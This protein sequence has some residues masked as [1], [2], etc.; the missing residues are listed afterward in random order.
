MKRSS[1][2]VVCLSVFVLGWVAVANA[3]ERQ[4]LFGDLHVHTRLSLDAW[5]FG[6]RTSPDDAYRFAKGEAIPHPSGYDIQLDRPLDFYAVTDHAN[7]LGVLHAMAD[8]ADPASKIPGA[9]RF[10]QEKATVR[11]RRADYAHQSQFA[12]KH[13]N[14][15]MKRSA[16]AR[17][18]E[19]ANRHNDPGEFTAF[20]GYE[21]TSHPRGQPA[22]E[23]HLPRQCRAGC[24]FQPFRI[25]QSGRAVGVDGRAPWPR[26]RGAG[27]PA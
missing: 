5:G 25:A 13:M 7:Y 24:A 12:L 21:Y 10:T 8:P 4:A 26:H 16:W 15:D 3:E 27:D 23:C 6:T 20:I 19:A 22:P 14:V 1:G 11:K 9:A 18:I 2:S 17:V